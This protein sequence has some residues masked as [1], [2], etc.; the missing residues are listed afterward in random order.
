ME[1]LAGFT[2]FL[3]AAWL[4]AGLIVFLMVL[5]IAIDSARL[6]R[7]ADQIIKLLSERLPTRPAAS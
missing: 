7:R 4:V 1:G 5:S 3:V 2:F 6:I